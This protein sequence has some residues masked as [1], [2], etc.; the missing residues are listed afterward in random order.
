MPVGARCTL[1]CSAVCRREKRL[2]FMAAAACCERLP[3][4]PCLLQ[5][6]AP[7]PTTA[8]SSG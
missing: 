4:L 2:V 6:K 1:Q 5:E 3:P 7:L 8:G